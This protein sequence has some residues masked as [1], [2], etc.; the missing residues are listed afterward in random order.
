MIKSGIYDYIDVLDKAADASYLRNEVLANNIANQDTPGF[1][2]RDVDFESVLTRELGKSKYEYL[3]D[4][5]KD[6]HLNHLNVKS[7]IDREAYDYSY[8][9][10]RNNVDPETEQVELAANQFTYKGLIQSMGDEF[11]RIKSAIK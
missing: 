10:D 5:I 8:R 4:K 1:K 6:I 2:R 9:L 3:D 7:R 11:S